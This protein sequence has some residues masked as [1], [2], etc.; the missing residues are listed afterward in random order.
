M[1]RIRLTALFNI[2]V[3]SA[4][5]GAGGD[6]PVA[7]SLHRLSTPPL[8]FESNRALSAGSES[9]VS[10]AQEYDVLVEKTSVS[11]RAGN[12]RRQPLIR[13]TLS[14]AD[15]NASIAAADPLSGTSSYLIGNDP[16]RWRTHVAAF[17]RVVVRNPWPGVSVTYYGTE[18]H[19]EY[20][21]SLDPHARVANV[22]FGFEG[23]KRVRIAQDGS[24]EIAAPSGLLRQ[25]P[26]IAYQFTGANRTPVAVS[27][28]R[29][30]K[31]TVG[32]ILGPH[33]PDLP[34][35]V[36][37]VLSY[38]TYLG[39]TSPVQNPPFTL[40]SVHGNRVAVDSTG[41]AYVL[42][43]TTTG[44]FPGFGGNMSGS[45][46]G[47]SDLY[48]AKL[49]ADGSTLLWATY[50][51]GNGQE[52]PG[53]IAV[54]P[55][56]NIYICGNTM[57]SDF[58]TTAGA[59][60]QT[61]S[62]DH[63][64][65]VAVLNPSG[66][67]LAYSSYLGGSS[68]Q[69]AYA[70]AV[71]PNGTA[72]VTGDT[73]S[74]DFPTTA[75]A[76]LPAALYQNAFFVKVNPMLSG[77]ASLVYSTLLSSSGNV[78]AYAIAADTGGAAYIAGYAG[79]G[80]PTTSGAFQSAPR[81]YGD[82]F[83]IK[84]D[85]SKPG[86]AG[87]LYAT[88]LG[89]NSSDESA[90]CVA[91]GPGGKI[92]VAGSTG[93]SDF[94]VTPGAY[95]S[96][97][98]SGEQPFVSAFDPTLS[99]NAS[100][101]YSTIAGSHFGSA[102]PN[103]MVAD[104]DGI[105]YLAGKAGNTFPTT[106]DAFQST[107]AGGISD[108]FVAKL[109]AQG[110]SLIYGT[111]FGGT[112]ADVI[113]GMA[114]G[115]GNDLIV[116]GDTGSTNF[117]LVA[118]L[119][120]GIPSGVY[121]MAFVARI[122]G[123]P[124]NCAFD[125][126]ATAQS[127]GADPGTG[128]VN[129]LTTSGCAWSVT[130]NNSWIGITNGAAGSGNGT[131]SFQIVAN[132]APAVRTGT[133]TIAGKTFT[134]TQDAAVC[135][136]SVLPTR[137]VFSHNAGI[138]TAS[139]G[140]LDHCPSILSLPDSWITSTSYYP[141]MGGG[142]LSFAVAAN[143]SPSNRTGSVQV[144]TAA[145]TVTQAASN[146]TYSLN[147]ITLY[148]GSAGGAQ[149]L[150]INTQTDC[151]WFADTP[152]NAL[153]NWLQIQPT[154]GT[155]PSTVSFSVAPNPYF[156]SRSDVIRVL[157]Q[158]F[159]VV[160]YPS[161]QLTITKTHTG[162]FALGQN[163]ATYVLTVS[164]AA[165]SG[166]TAG[167]VTVTETVPSGMMLV[168]MAG[169]GWSCPGGNTCTTTASLAGGMSYPPITV[170]V[171][172]AASAPAQVTNQASVSGGGSTV[173]AANDVTTILPAG[174]PAFQSIATPGQSGTS[175]LFTLQY[176]DPQG[177]GDFYRV[178]IAINDYLR[179]FRSCLVYYTAGADVMYLLDDLG[180][181]WLG[182]VAFGTP[183]VLTNS[184]CSLN[185][186]QSTRVRSGNNLTLNLYVTFNP[187]FTGPKSVFTEMM[188]NSAQSPGWATVGSFTVTAGANLSPTMNSLTPGSGSGTNAVYHFQLSDPDGGGDLDRIQ[189]IIQNGFNPANSCY[190]YYAALSGLVYLASD[191]PAI[192]L[193]P[194]LMGQS[195]TLQNSQCMLRVGTSSV[196]YTGNS[197]EVDLDI[198]YKTSFA[199]PKTVY[200]ETRDRSNAGANNWQA[201]GTWTAVGLVNVAPTVD[202]V[203]P[204]LGSGSTQTFTVQ[205]S[206]SNGYAD[207][208][209][210]QVLFNS[211]LN[212]GTGCLFQYVRG[213]NLIY[214]LNDAG[215]VWLGPVLLGSSATLQN[216]RCSLNVPSATASGTGNSL[217]LTLPLT[218]QTAGFSGLK[219]VY[220][221]ATDSGGLSSNWHVVGNW[222]VQ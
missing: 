25:H 149:S 184:Q 122:S 64:M 104:T 172:V 147:P 113:N 43:Y 135:T 67:A 70:I 88:L 218:F 129:V 163:A 93:S 10:R 78:A 120:S 173:A 205:F 219:S 35:T 89:G 79:F 50:L 191:N 121:G 76:Y 124:A 203:T 32:I 197:M 164:N 55:N 123:F 30:G 118:P 128:S 167:T 36:D 190:V 56:G 13:M 4:G 49:S 83:A 182:P 199:G 8:R 176:S 80:I 171:N 91:A 175:G 144:G 106:S 174:T 202:S 216:G 110:D 20:D 158:T 212:F 58:P 48:I 148:V 61:K 90:C 119:I 105:V 11:I 9:F 170:A 146:C 47:S 153:S 60:R 73:T 162:S 86:S 193:G 108:G 99:G 15:R 103:T 194:V 188:D 112:D 69:H 132:D 77:A 28:Y 102:T 96:S 2:L 51:G 208:D 154:F 87:L 160:Q 65:F 214:L 22:R 213:A 26:P 34:V 117:P 109:S 180:S 220:G 137:M 98:F 24:L 84:L 3:A 126:S 156:T 14:G 181:R 1:K 82:A 46:H 155:G 161:P 33:D 107:F 31:R 192:F 142:V 100:L 115:P 74:P 6:A 85:P 209:R 222:T 7:A 44:Q 39:P 183:G 54:G 19:L 145:L 16:S 215:S 75:D 136:Y 141:S 59:I 29:A 114:L 57:S 127:A 63:D 186:P 165:A 221:E 45:L 198:A 95:Q 130:T 139:F 62:A 23:V 143:T 72:Y 71:G 18:G 168:S 66:T 125:L 134:I 169:T 17:Q 207:M 206:D 133:L 101:V 38:S 68:D 210:V 187:G 27:Y 179:G 94:P 116:T 159:T 138:G 81:G 201:M 195:V 140:T 204:P 150:A 52:D 189:V 177:N 92:I 40:P 151:P 211:S 152:S 217:Q 111:Y 157:D 178:Q 41:N 200:A 21:I 131:V 97:V 166:P 53:G 185:M 196:T 37:P 5:F 12:T 42:G